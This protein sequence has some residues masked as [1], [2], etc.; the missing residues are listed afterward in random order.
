MIIPARTVVDKH[1]LVKI[2]LDN[3]L[4]M[5]DSAALCDVKIC[6]FLIV[7]IDSLQCTL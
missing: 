1:A 3:S 2:S 4:E 6:F 5:N 7:K